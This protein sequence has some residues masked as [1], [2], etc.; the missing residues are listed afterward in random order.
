MRGDGRVI[1]VLVCH[2]L[3][4]ALFYIFTL[5]KVGWGECLRLE[6]I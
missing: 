1:V 6:L 3:Y 4:F 5:C 2:V